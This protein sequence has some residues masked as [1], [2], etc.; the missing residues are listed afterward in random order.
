[1]A[2]IHN[3]IFIITWISKAQIIMFRLLYSHKCNYLISINVI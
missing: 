2:I 3:A 1:M